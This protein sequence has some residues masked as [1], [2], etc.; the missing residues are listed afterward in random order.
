MNRSHTRL[1]RLSDEGLREEFHGFCWEMV[2]K[3]YMHQTD[4]SEEERSEL[5]GYILEF[6][7]RGV[8][9]SLF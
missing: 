8:Q 1:A 3:G 2:A 9:L 4:L 6:R 7:M 5:A